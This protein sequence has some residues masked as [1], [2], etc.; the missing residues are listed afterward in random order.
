VNLVPA[1]GRDY[2]SKAAVQADLDADTDFMIADASSPWDGKPVNAAQLRESG[3]TSVTIRYANLRKV[4][5]FQLTN[6]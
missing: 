2:K 5:V 4:A 3:E 1:Y 6:G